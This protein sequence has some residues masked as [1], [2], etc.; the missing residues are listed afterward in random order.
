MTNVKNKI[1]PIVQ[2]NYKKGE[3]VIKEGDYGISIYKLLKGK[4]EI[5][6]QS[7]GRE[8]KLATIGPGEIIGEM[9]FLYGAIE[10]RSASARAVEDSKMEIWHPS[11]LTTEY[12]QMP[13]T[14]KYIIDQTLRHL[15]RMNKV[16][17]S[18]T[19]KLEEEKKK[20]AA[21]EPLDSKRR[22]YRKEIEQLCEYRPIGSASDIHLEGVVK[23]ISR[24][25]L[26]LGISSENVA[27]VSHVPGNEFFISTTLPNEKHLDINAKIVTIRKDEQP[28]RVLLGMAFTR[29]T[30]HDRKILGFFLMP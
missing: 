5:F 7:N 2:L 11:R 15:I 6:T 19:F 8:I 16:Y 1:P 4:V 3:L 24:G 9:V 13:S 10:P 26:A 23:D 25:G 12:Q 28:G 14:L 18:L 30:D 29:L 27:N 21:G 20:E 22:Y 17:S